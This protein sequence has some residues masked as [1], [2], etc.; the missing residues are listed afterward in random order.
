MMS[1]SPFKFLMIL[2]LVMVAFIF[3]NKNFFGNKISFN[4]IPNFGVN[5]TS[6]IFGHLSGVK[7]V[8]NSIGTISTLV[9]QKLELEKK[10]NELLSKLADLENLRSEN[11]FLRKAFKISDDL[12]YDF[13]KASIYS[14]DVDSHGYNVM[15]NRGKADGIS[16][17]DIIISEDQVLM[18]IVYGVAD[19]FS[20]ILVVTDPR[21]KV[22]ARVLSSNT[23]GIASGELTQDMSF[24]L[25]IHNDEIKEG[26]V[27]VS[28]GNDKFPPSLIIGKVDKVD[29]A[30]NQLF[31]KVSIRPAMGDV[32]LGPV[33][34]LK[35]K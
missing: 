13:Q 30:E 16:D 28:S 27:V 34:V 2:I 20:R 26:D 18:G 1:R 14:W 31:K 5:I 29:I 10:N 24:N 17:G 23:T 35:K 7:K 33:V 12:G 22:T 15:L 19:D 8:I 3:L 9:N 6:S 21:F 11:I 4:M 25:I 32:V